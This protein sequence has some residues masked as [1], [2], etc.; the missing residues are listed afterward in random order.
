[1][2]PAN[3]LLQC[4]APGNRHGKEKSVE[5]CVVEAFADVTTC[6]EQDSFLSVGNRSQLFGDGTSLFCTHAAFQH[7][8]VFHQAGQP[9]GKFVH[10][11]GALGDFEEGRISAAY[12]V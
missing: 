3:V 9:G 12:M 4:A 6:R 11:A 10:L 2:K 1:M 8:D 5:S 7:H